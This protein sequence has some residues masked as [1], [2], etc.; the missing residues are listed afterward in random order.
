MEGLF[1]MEHTVI[2]SSQYAPHCLPYLFVRYKFFYPPNQ[3]Y[4]SAYTNSTCDILLFLTYLDAF[5]ASFCGIN[6]FYNLILTFTLGLNI[7]IP[8]Y[9]L[10]LLRKRK[11]LCDNMLKCQF[12]AYCYETI[13]ILIQTLSNKN[14]NEILTAFCGAA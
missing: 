7:S 6:S 13:L 14:I 1:G 10:F 9:F 2:S 8:S 12:P 11:I 3:Q 4:L 5:F